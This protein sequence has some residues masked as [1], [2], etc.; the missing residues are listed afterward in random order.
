M[1]FIQFLLWMAMPFIASSQCSTTGAHT[2][3]SVANNS[4][5]GSI[6]W[7]N[8]ANTVL[9]DNS[10]S[11]AGTLLGVLA[12]ANT[13]YL[14]FKDFNFSLPAGAAICGI[15]VSREGS[16]SGLLVGSSIRDNSVR[17]I[18]NNVIDGDDKAS[19]TNWTGSDATTTYGSVSDDWGLSWTA[20]DINSSDFGVAI[21]ARMSA[22]LASLFLTANVDRVSITVYYNLILPVQL[23]SFTAKA[24]Q[25]KVELNWATVSES[26]SDHFKIQRATSSMDWQTIATVE[27][28]GY[29]NAKKVYQWTDENPR[30]VNYYR[31]VQVDQ[32]NRAAISSTVSA[33]L[34]QSGAR[35]F[36]Y[37]NPVMTDLF[38]ENNEPIQSATLYNSYGQMVA[39]TSH[40]RSAYQWRL[41]C[42]GLRS[43][44]YLLHIQDKTKFERRQVVVN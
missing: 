28:A 3:S 40:K 24:N 30:P 27:A 13:Q 17:I 18:K 5:L 42:Q 8:L 7:S 19:A 26:N 9:S 21:S 2:S 33:S 44:I 20:A 22:G 29:S 15:E 39:V 43:G 25:H 1:K 32:D 14:V 10:Y 38:I 6:T 16:A 41:N 31:L 4:G 11:S 37:P 23:E 36:I 35:I 12:T 34:Q